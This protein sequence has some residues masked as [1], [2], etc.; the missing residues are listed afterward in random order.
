M[1]FLPIEVHISK[2]NKNLVL[3][4]PE[5]SEA[6]EVLLAMAEIARHSPYIISTEQDFLSQEV[7]QQEKWIENHQESTSSIA[8]C[9]FDKEKI[10]GLCDAR[11]YKNIKRKHRVGLGV[12]INKN[13][14][15]CGL[16]KILMNHLIEKIKTFPDIEIIELDVMASNHAAFKI[17]SQLGF[18]ETGRLKNAFKIPGLP[19]EEN[20]SMALYL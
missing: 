15:G 19:P 9:V 17:Y 14:R 16:G 3:R 8:I 10:V 5:V 4:S 18:V 12:S 13:Y 2:L 6:K 20:I 11:A 1:K 7:T